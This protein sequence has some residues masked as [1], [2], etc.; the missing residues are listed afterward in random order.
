M[1]KQK[2]K[3]QPDQWLDDTPK[4]TP[5]AIA[6]DDVDRI[7]DGFK[8]LLQTDPKYSL[9]IDPEH[10]YYFGQ[11]EIDFIKHMIQYKNV[12]FV[13]TVLMNISLEEGVEIYKRYDVQSEIKRINLAMYA[14]R[15]ATK[16][17]DLDALGGYLTS[18]LIDENV[19][20][21]DRWTPKD[22]LAA[23][24][25]L[26][27]LNAMKRKGLE[28]PMVIEGVEIQR[29]LERLSPNEL[30]QLIEYNGEE[31]E[32]KEKLIELINIDGLLSMEE[33]KNLRMMSLE[34]LQN[35]AETVAGGLEDAESDD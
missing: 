28:A 33:I 26:M 16:M 13:T 1:S 20:V 27:T 5:T 24:K 29:D 30:K 12:Q 23:T 21:A 10:K 8:E 31:A 14:R 3:K 17:A 32:E 6:Y 9:E 7:E 15:F 35:L 22:K 19:P 4:N 25:L 2:G 11:K 34:E 18:G